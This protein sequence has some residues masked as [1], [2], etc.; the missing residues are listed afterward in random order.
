MSFGQLT[1]IIPALYCWLGYC[2]MSI[3]NW[4][5]QFGLIL[6]KWLRWYTGEGQSYNS[7]YHPSMGCSHLYPCTKCWRRVQEGRSL[8]HQPQGWIKV[9][10]KTHPHMS[11]WTSTHQP[12]SV[13][14]WC[15]SVDCIT[16]NTNNRERHLLH[17]SKQVRSV[18]TCDHDITHCLSDL[19]YTFSDTHPS[20]SHTHKHTH[21][22]THNPLSLFNDTRKITH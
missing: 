8:S 19:I 12:G 10:L 11:L 22:H 15:V 3:H 17:V 4:G 21:T 7:G 16:D 9:T 20:V 18:R 13:R 5:W 2:V 14:W 1:T 6:C